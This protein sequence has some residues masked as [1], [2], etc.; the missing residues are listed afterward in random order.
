MIIVGPNEN[1]NSS[2]DSQ[3]NNNQT[4]VILAPYVAGLSKLL[5]II[6][7]RIFGES[8]DSIFNQ[9]KNTSLYFISKM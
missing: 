1:N 4:L 3:N 8:H 2:N 5:G 7:C 6:L 9:K